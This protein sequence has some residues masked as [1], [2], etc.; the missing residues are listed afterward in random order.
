MAHKKVKQ[1]AT[2]IEIILTALAF[3]IGLAFLIGGK[4]HTALYNAGGLRF[5]GRESPL[6]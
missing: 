6:L 2:L 1:K 5:V 4:W 3:I